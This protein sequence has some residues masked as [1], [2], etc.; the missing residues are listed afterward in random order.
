MRIGG[1]TGISFKRNIKV[2]DAHTHDK[3]FNKQGLLADSSDIT[4]F[5]NKEIKAGE[6]TLTVTKMFPSALDCCFIDKNKNPQIPYA[7]ELKGNENILKTFEGTDVKEFL[8]VCEPKH[9]SAD[10]IKN[11]FS[12][13]PD[14]FIGL[15]FHPNGQEL[16]AGSNLY[17]PYMQFAK[18]NN[19]PC[20]FHSDRSFDK[21]YKWSEVA[22]KNTGATIMRTNTCLKSQ[23][24]RPE[25]IYAL[26]KR[27]P[28]VPIVMAHCG[29]GAEKEDINA[30]IDTIITSAKNNDA[31]LYADISWVDIDKFTDNITKKREMPNLVE[32]I[33][34]LKNSQAGDLTGRIM[35]GT[36]APIDRFSAENAIKDYQDYITD[37]HGAIK[38]NFGDEADSIIDKIFFKNADDLY[39]QKTWISKIDET[40]EIFKNAQ[41]TIQEGTKKLSKSKTPLVFL[42]MGILALI[43]VGGILYNK[44]KAKEVNT[45]NK[46]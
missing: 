39:I 27:H 9:G 30:V 38:N 25:Q 8:A 11:L 3:S 33:K 5:I 16:E 35:F 26:A 12:K 19:L 28:E 44:H 7:D 18:E 20:L 23:Y 34:K 6:D 45:Q 13:Y 14:K 31:K 42:G 40:N 36:D 22:D 41:G 2:I 1:I 15:K 21:T 10:N 29:G 43:G 24:S 32:S 17:D 37:I 4:K 46:K